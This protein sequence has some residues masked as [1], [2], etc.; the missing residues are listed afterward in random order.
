MAT[1]HG[2]TAGLSGMSSL[3]LL[4]GRTQRPSRGPKPKLSVERIARVSID[5]ADAEGL[6]AV[7]MQRVANELGFT[8]MALYRYVPAKEQLLDVMLDIACGQPPDDAGGDWRAQIEDWAR[9]MLAL[10]RRHPWALRVQI[11]GPPV[12]P[13]QLGWFEAALRPLARAGLESQDMVAAAMF[14]VGSVRELARISTEIAQGRS[15]AG[16]SASEAEAGFANALRSYVDVER[17]PTLAGIVREGVFDPVEQPGDIDVD[18]DFGVQ[19]LLDGI[20]AYVR[21]SA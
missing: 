21:R 18:L 16:V 3:E 1:E 8:T 2:G 13:G 10:F 6:D 20:D 11:S 12:G 14:L 7:S 4:W 15:A 17:F 19:R 9:G 5:I